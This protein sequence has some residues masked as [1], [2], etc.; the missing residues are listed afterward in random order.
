MRL[1]FGSPHDRR[2]HRPVWDDRLHDFGPAELKYEDFPKRIPKGETRRVFVDGRGMA[3]PIAHPAAFDGPPRELE[4]EARVEALALTLRALYRF[5]GALP[6]GLHHDARRA[7][8][9]PLGGATF[10][11]SVNGELHAKGEYANVYPNDYV[12]TRE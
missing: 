10:H 1:P 8:G 11:C 7:D 5:G 2:P 9:S 4:P 12:R 3:F 6:R